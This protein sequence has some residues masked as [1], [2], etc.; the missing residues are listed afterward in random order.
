MSA[1][2]AA[3]SKLIESLSQNDQGST[4]Q[5]ALSNL[6]GVEFPLDTGVEGAAGLIAEKL[7]L[8][9]KS[10]LAQ[11][12]MY[13]VTKAAILEG[14]ALIGIGGGIAKLDM[15]GFQ[16]AKLQRQVEAINLKLEIV[17]ST[18]LELAIDFLGKA[19]R[20]MESQNATDTIKELEKV[21]DHAMQAFHYVKGQGATTDN[22]KN[23]IR[24]KQLS[25]FSEILTKGYD[26]TKVFPFSMLDK[27]K[28]KTIGLLIEDEISSMQ[29]FH[30]SQSTS[31]FTFKKAEK[32]KQRQDILDALLKTSYPFIS[33][34]R[35]LTSAL[36]PMKLCF[37][38]LPHLLPEGEEDSTRV[39]IGHLQGKP[40]AVNLW[41]E[42]DVVMGKWE[43][44]ESWNCGEIAGTEIIA[45]GILLHILLK[46]MVSMLAD[47]SFVVTR[48]IS[49]R[50]LVT[51]LFL[52][53]N[54]CL[55]FLSRN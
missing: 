28:K 12:G 52:Q 48:A 1:D 41:K 29:K 9:Q 16:L 19:M 55:D 8:N 11:T 7:G 4:A 35:G 50:A 34:G 37:K 23:A 30:N 6:L 51:K 27:Q 13:V 39:T 43:N 40:F 14:A 21:K 3:L 15:T 36:S 20:H 24:A 22:L 18:P 44:G 32:A 5:Q 54:I 26:G 10:T 25:I 49:R 53:G 33:E 45:T 17:L 47:L 42:N 31:M 46:K 2:Q 38:L